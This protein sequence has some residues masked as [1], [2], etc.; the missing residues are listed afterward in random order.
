VEWFCFPDGVKLWRGPHPPTNSDFVSAL[1][2]PPVISQSCAKVADTDGLSL[3]L[4][5]AHLNCT[6]S[7]S[8]F[9]IASNS[10]EYG[11]ATQKTYGA[12]IRFFVPAPKGIDPTQDDFA[13]TLMGGVQEEEEE[14]DGN[15]M[16]EKKRL[17]VPIGICI[18]SSIPIVGT[19]E[20]ALMR[21]CEMLASRPPIVPAQKNKINNIKSV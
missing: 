15:G 2:Q 16:E 14:H 10:D 12:V 18:T 4:F 6:T 3:A 11:S 19:M 5:D 13:Q 21:T 9:V 7:F 8:W 20:A 1:A 17:W